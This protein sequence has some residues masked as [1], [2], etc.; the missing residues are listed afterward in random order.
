MKISFHN[1]TIKRLKK[2]VDKAIEL[3]NFRLFKIAKS[4]LL[5]SSDTSIADIAKLF[6]VSER[7]IYNWVSRFMVERFTWLFGFHYKGR[8]PK[9]RLSKKQKDLVYKIVIAGP[10]KYGF[11]CGLWNSSIIAEVIFREFNVV[12]NPR[13]L[14]RLLKK[15]GLSFQKGTFEAERTDDNEK[16]RK[17]WVN[18]KWPEILR[19]AKKKGAVILFGDEVSFAQ[20][21]SLSRTWA[22]IG[23][24]PKIKTKGKR[25]GLKMFGV[26]EFFG[27]SFQYM[28]AENKFNGESY[29][30][31]IKHIM[32]QYT[33]PVI[34]VED[35]APYHKAKVVTKYTDDL[36]DQ[37]QLYV[38]R[39]PS[40]S[41]DFNPIEK[42]WKNTKRDATHCKF[43]PTFE[44]LRASVVK[45]FKKYMQDATKVICVMEK[46]RGHAGLT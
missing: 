12:Y 10:E 28:E 6:H 45:A 32:S 24:Q 16:K 35:G 3:N 30:S 41:P 36:K 37:G 22:P 40:Y 1:F 17:E 18:E 4:L 26:I 46:L 13:Y 44:D 11:D 15:M 29:I 5:V 2:L 7:T 42:L 21:G 34:L 33:C 39:L 27:G 38:Y 20:W 43:F 19:K 23:M 31:F 25:K 14:C 9:S 8:G